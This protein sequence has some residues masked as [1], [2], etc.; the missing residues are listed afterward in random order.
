MNDFTKEDL[1]HIAN[2]LV[3]IGEKCSMEMELREKLSLLINKVESMIDKYCE[4][5]L[6]SIDYSHQAIR[7]HK[8][9]DIVE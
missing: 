5:E 1:N 4:H 6:C 2:G 3:L 9:K 8:C 7:C